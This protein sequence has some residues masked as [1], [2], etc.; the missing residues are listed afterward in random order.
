MRRFA[1][2]QVYE[3]VD[4]KNRAV[5]TQIRNDGRAGLLRTVHFIGCP[6]TCRAAHD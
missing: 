5:V 2:G 6:P 4:G 1:V 3:S